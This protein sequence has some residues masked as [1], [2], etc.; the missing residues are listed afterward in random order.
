MSLYKMFGLFMALCTAANAAQPATAPAASA[1]DDTLDRR[2]PEVRFDGV[3][4]EKAID[5]FREQL[6]ANLVVNWDAMH[7]AG[8]EKSTPIKLHLWDVSLRQALAV[9]IIQA[10][11][12]KAAISYQIDDNI[13]TISNTMFDRFAYAREPVKLYDIRDLLAA[14]IERRK[15]AAPPPRAGQDA[16]FDQSQPAQNSEREEADEL[17]HLIITM[18]DRDSW[19]DNGGDGSVRSWSGRLFVS[20]SPTIQRHVAEFLARLRANPD[21]AK[22]AAPDPTPE[23]QKSAPAPNAPCAGR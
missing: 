19:A 13:V 8:I 18:I 10:S 17:C 5:S 12:G 23:N 15:A 21:A 20:N 3:P 22:P 1:D 14:S 11:D 16:L 4:L 6:R 9:L 2:L 7:Q